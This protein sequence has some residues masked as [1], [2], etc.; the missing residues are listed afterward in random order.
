MRVSLLFACLQLAGTSGPNHNRKWRAI[1]EMKG[2]EAKHA[3]GTLSMKALLAADGFE[4]SIGASKLHA[5][6]ASVLAQHIR[7]GD[8]IAELACGAGAL[9]FM[10][11]ER[12]PHSDISSAWVHFTGIDYAM[13]QLEVAVKYAQALPHGN[14]AHLSTFVQGDASDMNAFVDESFQLVYM[15]SA[16][17]YMDNATHAQRV[18][19]EMLRLVTRPGKVIVFDVQDSKHKEA[20]LA[21]RAATDYAGHQERMKPKSGRVSRLF[22]DVQAMLEVGILAQCEAH[23]FPTANVSPED[24][25]DAECSYNVIYICD[26]A[27]RRP[28]PRQLVHVR[29]PQP[30]RR[31][32]DVFRMTHACA[33]KIADA[34]RPGKLGSP[35]LDSK[36]M[37]A[38]LQ[39]IA[40]QLERCHVEYQ[41]NSGTL[42]GLWRDKQI[43]NGDNDID[44]MIS[45]HQDRGKLRE[46]LG[47][48]VREQRYG[49]T[50]AVYKTLR[51]SEVDDMAS[52]LQYHVCAYGHLLQVDI[53]FYGPGTKLI[54]AFPVLRILAASAPEVWSLIVADDDKVYKPWVL[55]GLQSARQTL[56]Q[57][58][59]AFNYMAWDIWMSRDGNYFHSSARAQMPANSLPHLR[60]GQGADLIAMPATA[61]LF[62]QQ[63]SY[64]TI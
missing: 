21:R 9:L 1:W 33:R 38:A 7:P 62:S 10:T 20:C 60:L 49:L 11:A 61:L 56:P 48:A 6:A 26:D 24:Y 40:R 47:L 27:T 3:I 23:V 35:H 28:Q 42:L 2:M 14:P 54:C 64:Q 39:V 45:Y 31:H 17:Q 30:D 12:V 8:K 22:I 25:V 15:N 50:G 51:L 5:F 44:L 46:C 55:Q 57:H 34:P 4:G 37:T 58:Q 41:V 36:T 43:V 18:V 32:P 29:E 59:H 53:Y 52:L 63:I 16:L 19:R 13:H